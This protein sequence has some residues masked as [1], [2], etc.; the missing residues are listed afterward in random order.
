MRVNVL[1]NT[2]VYLQ[3]NQIHNLILINVISTVIIRPEIIVR[4]YIYICVCV[5]VSI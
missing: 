1:H 4:M 2:H 3:Y 5:C